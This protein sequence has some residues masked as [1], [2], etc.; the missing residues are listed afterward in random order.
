MNVTLII[1]NY[2]KIIKMHKSL[3]KLSVTLSWQND[4]YGDFTA[5]TEVTVFKASFWDIK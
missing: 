3:Q 1:N 4:L 5:G 2:W